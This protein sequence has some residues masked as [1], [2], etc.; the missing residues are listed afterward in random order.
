[1]IVV[2]CLVIIVGRIHI[3]VR[4]LDDSYALDCEPLMAAGEMVVTMTTN[5]SI[6]TN[7]RAMTNSVTLHYIMTMIFYVWS[8]CC[9]ILLH[10]PSDC[11]GL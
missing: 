11:H 7:T 1:M 4:R 8:Y 3:N 10:I 6:P 2:D 9:H 5:N